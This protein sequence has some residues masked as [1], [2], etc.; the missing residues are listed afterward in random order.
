MA[1]QTFAHKLRINST[2]YHSKNQTMQ[3]HRH[4]II[5][6]FF[7]QYVEDRIQRVLLTVS[8]QGISWGYLHKYKKHHF[9]YMTGPFNQP[10]IEI[11][12]IWVKDSMP[13]HEIIYSDLYRQ[14]KLYLE[15]S[16][17][18]TLTTI[19]IQ[20]STQIET[21]INIMVSGQNLFIQHL[22]LHMHLKIH[23]QSQIIRL[24]NNPITKSNN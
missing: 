18:D 24:F 6:L 12:P 20:H 19:R 16:L 1:F 8:T 7:K 15:H 5:E 2:A 9:A 3:Q 23:L 14:K 22:L 21:S 13:L 10:Y 17:S 4:R 11:S